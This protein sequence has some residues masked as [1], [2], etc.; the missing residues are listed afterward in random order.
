[1]ARE[2]KASVINMKHLSQDIDD[3]IVINAAD[4]NGRILRIIFTQEAAAQLTPDTKVYLS[5]WHEQR[6]VKGY[7]VFTQMPAL[8]DEY[9][10][11]WEINY[12]RSM[13]Y[14]GDVLT[15][16]ELVDDIS[17]ASSTNF[18]IHV[19][20][21][22][23]DG[24]PFVVS[25]DFTIF[26]TAVITLNNLADQIQAKMDEYQ[27]DFEN[28]QLEHQYMLTIVEETH[29]LNENMQDILQNIQ[30]EVDNILIDLQQQFDDW[31]YF[32]ENEINEWLENAEATLNY[33]RNILNSFETRLRAAETNAANAISVVN[34][35]APVATSGAA[36]D[37]ATTTATGLTATNVED[38]L[39]EL[40]NIVNTTII[41][42]VLTWHTL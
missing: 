36:A 30:D 9:P 23:N 31:L 3:P 29:E 7:N 33:Y 19:L 15:C 38:A 11:V 40:N 12:P 4:A 39:T 21:D 13:L 17:I 5:W 16:I 24:E 2:L 8:S 6:N 28:M 41:D 22:P 18:M 25:D 32:Q 10:F 14:E 1:M 26:Q 34:N 20:Q 42:N 27:I 37:V 35:L